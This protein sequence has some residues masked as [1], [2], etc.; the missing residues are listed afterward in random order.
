[1]LPTDLNLEDLRVIDIFNNTFNKIYA[2]FNTIK[3]FYNLITNVSELLNDSIGKI[4]K[5][6][7]SKVKDV[8]A[9]LIET[10]MTMIKISYIIL[11]KH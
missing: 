11:K 2:V 6:C 3:L 5:E 9:D 7:K 1:M 4:N 8:C 10:L